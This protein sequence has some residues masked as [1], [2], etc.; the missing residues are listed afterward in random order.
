MHD[1]TQCPSDLFVATAIVFR[2]SSDL[3]FFISSTVYLKKRREYPWRLQH[4]SAFCK[5]LVLRTRGRQKKLPKYYII[6]QNQWS[7]EPTKCHQTKS[8]PNSI[9]LL[10]RLHA[11]QRAMRITWNMDM[12]CHPNE[13]NKMPPTVTADAD[14]MVYIASISAAL[15]NGRPHWSGRGGWFRPL[16]NG[17]Q[18]RLITNM[19]WDELLMYIYIYIYFL[20]ALVLFISFQSWQ[21]W[22]NSKILGMFLIAKACAS[23]CRRV[24]VTSSC[25]VWH[26]V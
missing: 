4:W 5:G 18:P 3:Q 16:T 2:L 14:M 26:I 11:C 25:S 8:H 6:L 19:I 24:C 12:P 13:S 10:R 17:S 23:T 20:K 7:K 9:H 1:A 22:C 21:V 15:S